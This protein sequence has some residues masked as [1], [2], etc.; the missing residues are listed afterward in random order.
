MDDVELQEYQEHEAPNFVFSQEHED[1]SSAREPKRHQMDLK[2]LLNPQAEV[3]YEPTMGD[4]Q[5]TP[6]KAPQDLSTKPQNLDPPTPSTP[7]PIR[8]FPIFDAGSSK[9]KK[10][11]ADGPPAMIT[12][13]VVIGTSRSAQA[14]RERNK[15]VM[16]GI[17]VINNT[18][19]LRFKRKI[20]LIDPGAEFVIDGNVKVM[21][22]SVCGRPVTMKEP[23]NTSH[24][25]RH[26]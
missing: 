14:A 10:R 1:N 17:F 2:S 8:L 6:V 9:G 20:R 18:L 13:R 12:H 15:Q 3:P 21:M 5:P 22:H 26:L 23:Y 19:L 7:Q 4:V 24:F 25:Y 16:E 11:K